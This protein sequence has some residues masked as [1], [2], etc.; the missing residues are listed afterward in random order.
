MIGLDTNVLLR[1]F[2]ADEN[3]KQSERARSFVAEQSKAGP[4]M[5]NA[6]VLAEFVWVLTKSLK[7]PKNDIVKYLDGL[8]QSDDLDVEQRSAAV[9]ALGAYRNGRADFADYLLA[10]INVELGCQSTASFDGNALKSE[11]FCPIP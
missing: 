7:M 1:L 9:A 3:P 2:I 11:L 6:I 5:V 8:L 10:L 4:L